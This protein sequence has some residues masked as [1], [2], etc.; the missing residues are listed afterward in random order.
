MQ[1]VS[2]GKSFLRLNRQ[3][4][5]EGTQ[6]KEPETPSPLL[7]T[8]VLEHQEHWDTLVAERLGWE[9]EVTSSSKMQRLAVTIPG[10]SWTHLL[11]LCDSSRRSCSCTHRTKCVYRTAPRLWQRWKYPPWASMAPSLPSPPPLSAGQKTANISTCERC[12]SCSDSGALSHGNPPPQQASE[13]KWSNSE[14]ICY[15]RALGA[16]HWQWPCL[17][18]QG[19]MFKVFI[20]V[21]LSSG[22]SSSGSETLQRAEFAG[23]QRNQEKY[24]H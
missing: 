24:I 20:S 23:S 7:L 1:N 6:P 12:H 15:Y 2:R 3:L 4:E 10:V 17:N 21:H 14:R 16:C 5:E 9:G 22:K 18:Q 19:N 13:G 8:A 11:K